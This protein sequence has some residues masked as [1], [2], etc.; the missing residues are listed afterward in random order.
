MFAQFFNNWLKT[1]SSFYEIFR[2]LLLHFKN[3]WKGR[4]NKKIPVKSQSKLI[5]SRI[6][7]KKREKERKKSLGS[8][9][10]KQHNNITQFEWKGICA[11]WWWKASLFSTYLVRFH[12]F[13]DSPKNT[14]FTITKI[15]NNPQ[16]KPFFW[17]FKKPFSSRNCFGRAV[18]SWTWA[19]V[20][21]EYLVNQSFILHQDQ[22]IADVFFS[23]IQIAEKKCS[24]TWADVFR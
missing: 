1:S 23:I 5:F 4:V 16:E 3:D 9:E 12:R 21:V 10:A 14:N 19:R 6:S 24:P 22:N 8:S 7:S 18:P 2:S 13:L 20:Q 15:F 11:I 17:R